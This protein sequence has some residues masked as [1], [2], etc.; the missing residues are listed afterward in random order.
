[1]TFFHRMR[2]NRLTIYKCPC[3]SGRPSQWQYDAKGI[4][5][6]RTCTACHTRKMDSVRED[7]KTD[8]NYWTDEPVEGD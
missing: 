6:F 3:G 8:P 2:S 1:M 7:V 5:L 4:A